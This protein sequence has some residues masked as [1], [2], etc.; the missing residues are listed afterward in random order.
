MHSSPDI[1]EGA[2][3]AVFDPV[4]VETA[5]TGGEML[6]TSTRHDVSQR[7]EKI[8]ADFKTRSL[9]TYAPEAVPASG[10]HPIEVRLTRRS[11]EIRA[12]R[13]YWR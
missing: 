1:D 5:E 2:P 13:G 12:R 9:L 7:F 3:P 11:G 8:V 4:A 6:Y 10:W